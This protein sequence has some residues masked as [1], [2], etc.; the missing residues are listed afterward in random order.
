MSIKNSTKCDNYNSVSVRELF[1]Q[2]FE[3]EDED[4]LSS[5]V[6]GNET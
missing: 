3:L 2:Q 6:K 5:I 4:F 1:L